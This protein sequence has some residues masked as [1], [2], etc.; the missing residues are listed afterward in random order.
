MEE[1]T[2][3]PLGH[4][5]NKG[6]GNARPEEAGS[7]GGLGFLGAQRKKGDNVDPIKEDAPLDGTLK[8]EHLDIRRTNDEA[9]EAE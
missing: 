5:D 2:G 7:E 3:K 1:K 8:K 6:E 9:S 4:P